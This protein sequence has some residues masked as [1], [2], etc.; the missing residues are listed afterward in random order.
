M[1]NKLFINLRT[2]IFLFFIFIFILNKFI[3]SISFINPYSI[4]L[5]NENILVIHKYGI[6]ICN[7]IATEII[8]NILFLQKEKKYQQKQLYQK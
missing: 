3:Y 4:S 7:S 1:N 5:S 6:S 2:K 8:D